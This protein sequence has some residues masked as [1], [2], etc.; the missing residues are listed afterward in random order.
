VPKS[1]P[2]VGGKSYDGMPDPEAI[3][4][5][6][7]LIEAGPFEVH[8]AQSFPLEDAANAHRALETHYVGKLA[9]HFK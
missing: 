3:E 5:L 4:Q 2:G 9:L 6:N 7:R 8:V 1:P